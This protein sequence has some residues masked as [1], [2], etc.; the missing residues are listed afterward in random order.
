MYILYKRV[1]GF[2]PQKC[3]TC[4]SFLIGTHLLFI[5]IVLI[6]LTI[7][8]VICHENKCEKKIFEKNMS[9]GVMLTNDY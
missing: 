8:N 9:K 5:F 4:L 6:G 1:A 2:D 3:K 7:D